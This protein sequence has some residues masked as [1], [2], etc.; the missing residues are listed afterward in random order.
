MRYS[1]IKYIAQLSIVFLGL[2]LIFFLVFSFCNLDIKPYVILQEPSAVSAVTFSPDGR[3]I[4]SSNYDGKVR[5]YESKT[6]D[7]YKTLPYQHSEYGEADSVAFSA[8]DRYLASAHRKNYII[9][10][11][12]LKANELKMKLLGHKDD[13]IVMDFSPKTNLLASGSLDGTII[14]WD[15]ATQKI[16]LTLNDERIISL[17]FSADG[18]ILASTGASST[19]I[20]L[21]DVNNGKLVTKLEGHRGNVTSV[22]F[23]KENTELISGSFDTTVRFWDLQSETSRLPIPLL[24]DQI[25]RELKISTDN[26]LLACCYGDRR[27]RKDRIVIWELESGRFARKKRKEVQVSTFAVMDFTPDL[28]FFVSCIGNKIYIYKILD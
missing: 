4:A 14:I 19:D 21:W 28:K 16:K 7:L 18:K 10:I 6:G 20:K 27:G 8:D 11:W 26:N 15:L 3:Y 5:I 23:N 13:I 9:N 12:D 24:Y 25:I 22:Q 2:C 17:V 1:F